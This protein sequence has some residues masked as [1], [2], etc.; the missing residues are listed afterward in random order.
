MQS[1]LRFIPHLFNKVQQVRFRRCFWNWYSFT[2]GPHFVDI[3]RNLAQ[4]VYFVGCLV[5]VF[6]VTAPVAFV[7]S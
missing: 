7:P 5:A 4:P 6:R 3:S 2:S 1:V